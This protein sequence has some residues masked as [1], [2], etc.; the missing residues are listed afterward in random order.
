LVLGEKLW[1]GRAKTTSFS[2]K[3]VASSGIKSEFTWVA[4]LKGLGKALSVDGYLTFTERVISRPSGAIVGKGQGF[5]TTKEGEIVT[6]RGKGQSKTDKGKV[7]GLGLWSLETGSQRL[8]WVN[9][10]IIL[11]T[12]DWHPLGVDFDI[13]IYQWE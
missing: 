11:L 5:F 2:V 3:S 6:I 1:E 7:K 9:S 10:E 8:A 13:S 4:D 12:H